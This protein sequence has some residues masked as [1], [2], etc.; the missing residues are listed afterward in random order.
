MGPDELTRFLHEHLP[1]SR[2]MQMRVLIREPGGMRVQMPIAGNTNPHGTVFGG[3]LTA[4]GLVCGWTFLHA[5]LVDAGV[6]A[7]L[8]GKRSECDFLAPA[9]ADCI[10]ETLCSA[11][12]LEQMV[13]RF[14]Q[15]GRARLSLVTLIRSG[16]VD[17]ARH[18][19]SFTAVRPD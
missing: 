2:H 13:A 14:R 8:L 6:Q 12:D 7:R 10:A 3:A 17:V 5:A 16:P 4:L 18:T 19:G 9:T 15:T 11:A 1:L